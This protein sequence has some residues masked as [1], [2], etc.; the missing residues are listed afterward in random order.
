MNFLKQIVESV[1]K[2]PSL[3]LFVF[4][5]IFSVDRSNRW[6]D[7]NKGNFPFV[8]DVNQYYSYLPA[9]F[10]H[11]DLTFSFQNDYWTV[12]AANGNHI[13][14]MTYGMALLYS[15]FFLIGH[16]VASNKGVPQDGYSLPYK[17]W[18]HIGTLFY[19][20]LGLWFC[21]KNLLRFFNE[22]VTVIALLAVFLGTNLF[23]YTYCWGEMSH[24]YLFCLISIFI[25]FTIKW[26]DTKKTKYFLCFSIVAGFVT[27]IRPTDCLILVFPLL[28]G[29]KSIRDIKERFLFLINM[30]WNLLLG[31]VLFVLPFFV[32][33]IYWRIFAGQ[34]LMYTYGEKEKF[35]FND[36][37]IMNFL[38]SFRKGWFIYTPIMFFATL[39]IGFLWKK[40]NELFYFS[41][42]F[43]VINVYVLSSWWD[44][45]FGGSF[46]SRAVI[47][48]YS[49]FIFG[50][51]AFISSIFSIFQ[52]KKVL[53]NVIK[54][55]L[56][57]VLAFLINVNYDQSWK[58]KYG[59]IHYNGMTKDAYFYMVNKE[60]FT[61][62]ELEEFTSKIKVPD[63]D[64]MLNGKRDQ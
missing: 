53:N 48:H 54:V 31:I 30:N 10:I 63:I 37:Q 35:F 21:R 6:F 16:I 34:W 56:S 14:R 59:L 13:P 33:M 28:I 1:K 15:P 12:K 7:Y 26:Y 62:E 41:I 23:Y 44:W 47:Q 36:P 20:L 27:L 5:I 9:A 50:L 49:F 11:H 60:S 38:F 40:A 22:W 64:A 43:F 61:K 58:Y 42:I 2:K 24:S 18:I 51:A 4:L 8:D 32:Q 25:Y 17:W 55:G 19:V 52:Q 3:Y 29:V 45:A 46:G 39:G 57:C